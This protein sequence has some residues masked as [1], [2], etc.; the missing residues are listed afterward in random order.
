MQNTQFYVSVS[1]II[2]QFPHE[3]LQGLLSHTCSKCTTKVTV[4]QANKNYN[5]L[6]LLF[7][8]LI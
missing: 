3:C 1:L 6:L 7:S 5:V 4:T 2:H 8:H